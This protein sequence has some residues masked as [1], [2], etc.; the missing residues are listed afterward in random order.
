ML[1]T[2]LVALAFFILVVIGMS[3]GVWL[4]KKPKPIAGS[5]GGLNKRYNED[6]DVI[7]DLCA[8]PKDSGRLDPL[9]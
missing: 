4:S 1:P 7:C 2:I 9:A 8:P 6:G 5:C 3:V